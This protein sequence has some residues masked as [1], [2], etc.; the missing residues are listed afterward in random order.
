MSEHQAERVHRD[1][2]S[3]LEVDSTHAEALGCAELIAAH[4]R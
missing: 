2:V 3:D 4:V 1:V